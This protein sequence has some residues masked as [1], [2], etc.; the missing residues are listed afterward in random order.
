MFGG[1]GGDARAGHR[2]RPGP[3]A[4]HW[5]NGRKRG[6][7]AQFVVGTVD[8]VLFAGLDSRH[9]MLRHLG[10]AGKVVIINECPA[11]DV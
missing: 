8:Q 11:Y 4:H 10:L 6:P 2:P 3:V 9:L 1:T 5:L 7:L